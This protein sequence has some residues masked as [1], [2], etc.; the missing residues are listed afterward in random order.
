MYGEKPN[1]NPAQKRE[2]H[3]AWRWTHPTYIVEVKRRLPDL[4]AVEID[5]SKRMADT[6]RKNN[7]LELKW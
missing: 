3:D 5:P 4:K 2:V 1:E 6:E 7:L